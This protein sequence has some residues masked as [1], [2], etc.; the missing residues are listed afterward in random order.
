MI[1]PELIIN[2]YVSLL[3][4]LKKI[5]YRAAVSQMLRNTALERLQF[6]IILAK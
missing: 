5:I 3:Y 1:M 2:T 4:E 6:P